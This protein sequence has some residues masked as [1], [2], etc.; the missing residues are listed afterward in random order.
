M[1]FIIRAPSSNGIIWQEDFSQIADG[2]TEGSVYNTVASGLGIS[3]QAQIDDNNWQPLTDRLRGFG[4]PSGFLPGTTAWSDTLPYPGGLVSAAAISDLPGATGKAY[5]HMRAD[6]DDQ[7]AAGLFVQFDQNDG[8]AFGNR[9][10]D[11]SIVPISPIMEFYLRFYIRYQ[12]GF[13]WS[14]PYNPADP[15]HPR[16][17]YDKPSYTKELYFNTSAGGTFPVFLVGFQSNGSVFGFSS[18]TPSFANPSSG[19]GWTTHMGTSLGT[20][21]WATM[22]VGDGQWYRYELHWRGGSSNCIIEQ[23]I[24]GGTIFSYD[25][26]ADYVAAGRTGGLRDIHIGS[27]SAS[28]SNFHPAGFVGQYANGDGYP[29]GSYYVDLAEFVMRAD[30]WVGPL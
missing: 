24:N 16:T 2:L 17:A 20:G 15:T 22:H 3:T 6:G 10:Y 13:K 23:R 7:V 11:S 19:G 26:T 8:S 30:T 12:A 1:P 25:P 5:R 21:D 18:V 4:K 14:E 27:N 29:Q 9:V 28:P